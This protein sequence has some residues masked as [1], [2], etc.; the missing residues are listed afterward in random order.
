MDQRTSGDSRAGIPF[1][2]YKSLSRCLADRVGGPAYAGGVLI[3]S[4]S[5]FTMDKHLL[6]AVWGLPASFALPSVAASR[7]ALALI[8]PRL[9]ELEAA[10][11]ARYPRLAAAAPAARY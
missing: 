9:R 1:R 6:G 10:E 7:R 8:R 5:D 4:T 11:A 3:S 2:S